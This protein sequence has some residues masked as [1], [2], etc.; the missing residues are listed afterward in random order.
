MN[1]TKKMLLILILLLPVLLLTSCEDADWDLLEIYFES[2][3]EENGL[4]EDGAWQPDGVVVKAVEDKV[5]DITNQ[6]AA[7]QL[8]A[9]DVV[10]DIDKTEELI[11]QAWEE[12]DQDKMIE[13]MELRPDDWQIREQDGIFSISTE[14]PDM[15][16]GLGDSDTIIEKQVKAGGDCISLRTQQLEYRDALLEEKMVSDGEIAVEMQKI[17][18]ETQEELQRIYGTNVSGYCEKFK[19]GY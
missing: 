3:A 7:V 12:N 17:Q 18:F 14:K 16:L 19:R 2:W 5:A 9:L 8:D 6:N 15:G 13:A 10:R 1:T 4:L 11:D